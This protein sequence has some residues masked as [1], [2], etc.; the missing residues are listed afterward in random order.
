[1]GLATA[2]SYTYKNDMLSIYSGKSVIDRLHLTDQTLHGFVVEK[3]A[4]SVN[5]VAIL[6]PAHIP[7]G[8]PIQSDGS[9]P[10]PQRPSRGKVCFGMMREVLAD[11]AAT[12]RV[13]AWTDR[14]ISP[15]PGAHHVC[16]GFIWGIWW[17]Q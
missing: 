3:G 5:I 7:F 17:A 6:D 4:G 8:L 12:H 2:D 1:M 9:D 10:R 13:D 15:A 14:G 11:V 16:C